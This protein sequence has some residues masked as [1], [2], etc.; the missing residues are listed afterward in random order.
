MQTCAQCGGQL[1][2][3]SERCD[4]CG[5]PVPGATQT[6]ADSFVRIDPARLDDAPEKR[7]AESD[8][9]W[10]RSDQSPTGKHRKVERE[11]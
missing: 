3:A 9:Q 8:G 2:G 11:P 5:A 10:G 4:R 6:K 1:N 7:P